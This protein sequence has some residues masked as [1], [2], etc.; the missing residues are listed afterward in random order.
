MTENLENTAIDTPTGET[1]A[2]QGTVVEN[3]EDTTKVETEPTEAVSTDKEAQKA[4]IRENQIKNLETNARELEE[5]TG[6]KLEDLLQAVRSDGEP[7]GKT[8]VETDDVDFDRFA[9]L[10]DAAVQAKFGDKFA[11]LD[12]MDE[13]FAKLEAKEMVQSLPADYKEYETD[14]VKFLEE[15]KVV[16][17]SPNAAKIAYNFVKGLNADK[18]A[19]KATSE[20]QTKVN[21]TEEIKKVSFVEDGKNSAEAEKTASIKDL[22]NPEVFKKLPKEERERILRHLS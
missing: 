11:R 6:M 5:T 4:Q 13:Y 14:M 19:E 16:A 18:I 2:E 9:E 20:L 22:A 8:E 1:V 17:A 21:E 12:R 15:N 10:T 7:V 3:T